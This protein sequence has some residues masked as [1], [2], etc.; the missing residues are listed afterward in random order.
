M[1]SCARH[2][3]PAEAAKRLGVTVK[4][5]RLY[6]RHGLVA[7]LRTAADWRT[8]GPEQMARLHQVLA[9]KR[10]GLSLARIAELLAGRGGT[11]AAVL[12]LQEQ[13]LSGESTRVAHALALVRAARARLSQGENLSVNDLATLTRETTMA[14]T[15]SPDEVKKLFEPLIAKHFSES[16]LAAM[17]RR[18]FD[19]AIAQRQWE[20]VIAEARALMAKGEDPASPAARDLGRRWAALVAEFSG[21]VKAIEQS[22]AAMWQEAMAN[23]NAADKLPLNPEIFAFVAKAQ[24][25]AKERR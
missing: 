11:L 14:V 10:M 12:A 1:N 24:A 20:E 2:L 16:D 7:P 23:P 18:S 13:V 15:P 5:L 17:R 9:L 21:G 19:P 8:Y 4:A 3:S 22:A 6:E 25:A